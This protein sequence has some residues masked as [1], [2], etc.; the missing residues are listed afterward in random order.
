MG[1]VFRADNREPIKLCHA[2][3]DGTKAD[4]D[5]YHLVTVHSPRREVDRY[6]PLQMHLDRLQAN[7]GKITG[8]AGDEALLDEII[9]SLRAQVAWLRDTEFDAAVET[10]AG[11]YSS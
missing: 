11:Y 9:A 8:W 4:P 10:A 7:R 2:N 6:L 3:L 5:C 1:V